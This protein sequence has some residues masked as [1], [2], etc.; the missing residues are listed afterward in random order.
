MLTPIRSFKPIRGDDLPTYSCKLKDMPEGF[1]FDGLVFDADYPRTYEIK[2]KLTEFA[3]L[4]YQEYEVNGRTP[5]DFLHNIQ[6]SYDLNKTIYETMLT[7]L[8]N[9]RFEMGQSVTEAMQGKEERNRNENVNRIRTDLSNGS[10]SMDKDTAVS[11]AETGN[12]VRD[13]TDDRTDDE[14][15]TELETGRIETVG[16]ATGA[17]TETESGTETTT[18]DGTTETVTGVSLTNTEQENTDTADNE[19][20]TVKNIV[21][22]FDGNNTDPSTETDRDMDRTGN[23]KRDKSSLGTSE[24]TETKTDDGTDTVDRTGNKSTSDVHDERETEDTDRTKS[25]TVSKDSHGVG[26]EKERTDRTDT[27]TGTETGTRKVTNDR[28]GSES[29]ETQ[30]KS[31]EKT[32]RLKTSIISRFPNEESIN[33]VV[34][35]IDKYPNIFKKFV[36]IF[37][38]D[39]VHLEVL[40]W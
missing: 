8:D 20:E 19:D 2:D 35:L 36:E 39:F 33:Y 16:T 30:T 38:E 37:D 17:V 9:V 24:T 29:G 3:N 5:A 4:Y 15:E 7:Q 34:N 32:D 23:V 12:R 31:D 21:L 11:R 26:N 1:D 22:A 10:E 25:N 28:S 13:T 40:I 27:E 14:T 18:K 6:V